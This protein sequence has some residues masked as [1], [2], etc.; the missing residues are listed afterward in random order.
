VT[1][2]VTEAVNMPEK[3]GSTKARVLDTGSAVKA[4]ICLTLIPMVVAIFLPWSTMNGSGQ[5]LAEYAAPTPSI[6]AWLL[7]A[8]GLA[9]AVVSVGSLVFGNKK[10]LLFVAAG[11]LVYFAGS[12]VWYGVT[13][14]P[15]A[16]AAGCAS[17]PGTLCSSSPGN[18][19]FAVA[20]GS[21]FVVAVIFGILT[22]TVALAGWVITERMA[23]RQSAG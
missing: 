9:L 17:N 6:V 8:L 14:L 12:L 13:I 15:D 1:E 10:S 3:P 5:G 19:T 23:V 11:A 7:L 21:G 4:L 16:V 2:Q 20:P 18:P 22:A